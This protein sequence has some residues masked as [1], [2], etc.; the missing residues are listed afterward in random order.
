MGLFFKLKTIIYNTILN[1]FEFVFF[2][3][4]YW[5]WRLHFFLMYRYW[6]LNGY[7]ILKMERDK[8]KDLSE[9]NFTPGETSILTTKLLLQ[10][11][12]PPKGGVIYDLGCGR[13]T[14]LFGAYFMYGMRGVGV[15]LLSTYIKKGK[16][17]CSDMKIASINFIQGN[18]SEVNLKDA[19]VVYIAATT[20]QEDV[21]EKLISNLKNT[22]PET[23][24]IIVHKPIESRDFTLIKQGKYPFSW[25]TD[26][27]FFY[28]RTPSASLNSP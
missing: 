11:I 25:G 19:D 1:F 6:G 13:G 22:E 26:D 15:D 20:F 9:R 27:V 21:M 12:N 28:K 18:I 17:I 3:T 7:T 24:I 16:R 14:V 8:I 4:N 23:I 5:W 10:E 2:F